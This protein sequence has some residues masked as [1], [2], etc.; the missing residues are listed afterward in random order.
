MR[1]NPRFTNVRVLDGGLTAWKA[2]GGAISTG[3]AAGRRKAPPRLPV[4]GLGATAST[5]RGDGVA[6]EVSRPAAIRLRCQTA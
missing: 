3:P 2:A 1:P 4:R 6:R 5:R